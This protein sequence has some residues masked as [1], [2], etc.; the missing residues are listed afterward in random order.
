[1]LV[2]R[3]YVSSELDGV[4]IEGVIEKRVREAGRPN[5]YGRKRIYALAKEEENSI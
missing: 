5:I 2:L 3:H 1:M 4:L